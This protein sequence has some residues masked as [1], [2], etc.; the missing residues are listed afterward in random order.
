MTIV[1][2]HV[3]KSCCAR[4]AEEERTARNV[5]HSRHRDVQP[6]F[7]TARC[8]KHC[9][10]MHTPICPGKTP[11][12]VNLS[13]RAHFDLH[14]CA[15]Q[16]PFRGHG[17][18]TIHGRQPNVLHVNLSAA[19]NPASGQHMQASNIVQNAF[20]CQA[21]S[22]SVY[23]CKLHNKSMQAIIACLIPQFSFQAQHNIYEA[24]TCTIREKISIRLLIQPSHRAHMN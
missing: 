21:V 17:E 11:P 3:R 2:L 15:L 1:N 10:M 6:N 4:H 13:V 7:C 16:K 18:Y 22:F 19:P 14:A 12:R 8:C 24:F 5:P 23:S 9:A 20:T